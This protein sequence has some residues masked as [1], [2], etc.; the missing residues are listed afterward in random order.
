VVDI[1]R[2][3]PDPPDHGQRMHSDLLGELML[4]EP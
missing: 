2:C 1:N 3:G 4:A